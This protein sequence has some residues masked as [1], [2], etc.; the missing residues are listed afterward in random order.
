MSVRPRPGASLSLASLL[1]LSSAP[2]STTAC[3]DIPD[4]LEAPTGAAA[5]PANVQELLAR[6]IAASGGE[7][8][9]RPLTQRTVEARVVFRA[10]ENCEPD[11]QDCVSEESTG[12]FVLYSTADARMYRR[13]VVGDNVLERGFDGT[14][15]WQM[16]AEPQLL[17]LEDAAATPI[18]REDALLHW[19]LDLD[20]RE[21]LALELLPTRT[22][23]T[24]DGERQLDGVR[25]F[26][27]GPG[28]PESEKWF[29]RDTGLLY[30]ERERDL[31]TGDVV[32]RVYS[33]YREVDGVLVAWFIEQ[34]TEVGDQAPQI[35]ELR[36]QVVHHRPVRE[37]MFAVPELGPVEP[38]ADPLLGALEVA[39]AQAE[40]EPK[41]L[42]IQVRFAR[43]AFQ[44]AHFADAK[45]AASAALKLDRRELEALYI[46]ARIALLD[47]N[48][49]LAESK[50]RAAVSAGLRPDEAARQMA[51]INL[52][53]GTWKKAGES[54]SDAGFPEIGERYTAFSGK[55]F[56]AKMG[57]GCST[58]LPIVDTDDD[59]ILVEVEADGETLK[60][61]FDT[62]AS[63]II[64]SD[65][66][67]RSLVIGTDAISPIAAGGPPLAQGQLET[68]S[69]G[70]LQVSNVPVTM[71]P[72]DQ[73]AYVVGMEGV[74]GVLGMRVFAGRQITVDHQAMTIEIV[75][76]SKK[77][78]RELAAR[79]VGT[80]VPFWMHE[81]HYVYL[82]GKM[83]GAE[84]IYLLNTGMRGAD[85]T[86]N[87]G[88]Y[89]YGGIGAPP[90][91]AGQ[92]TLAQ[93]ERFE[94]G[95]YTVADAGAAWG[96]LQQNATSDMFRLDGMLGLGMLGGG[97]WTLDFQTQELY[98][99]PPTP[100]KAEPAKAEPAKSAPAK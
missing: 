65:A 18:L 7:E 32:R 5:A 69:L 28:T 52:R 1:L 74:D 56:A 38:L 73:L 70:D 12:Q 99:S 45:R 23:E 51:W 87:E 89:A 9:L 42:E 76:P 60:L 30:E 91:I 68:L 25:W 84:G 46:L 15:G 67:A 39:R 86:A 66:K 34:I 50:L 16:Q 98:L 64:M 20:S 85:M 10:Q 13:M 4:G 29:A 36:M 24:P 71:F 6:H 77:C 43:A 27:S 92:P 3:L 94:L 41:D 54:L 72:A 57:H 31:E 22:V 47:G 95:P 11:A 44:A 37:E 90:M 58:V 75:E 79:R 96:F 55:P 78:R 62:G 63:D 19:Y 93:V 81:T 17:V 35:V 83:N 33:D 100:T 59:V 61:L 80:S 88:A 26:A 82:L 2:I 40:A 8:A 48:L 14:T 97:R 53:R 21:E 49:K